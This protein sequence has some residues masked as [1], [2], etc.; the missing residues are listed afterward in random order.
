VIHRYK[1]AQF[2]TFFL[3][4]LAGLAIDLVG[5]HLLVMWG[6]APWQ[7]NAI[8]STV[9]ISA[10]YFLVTRYSFG[11]AQQLSTYALFVGWYV[12]SILMFSTVIQV[13]TSVSGLDA[14]VWKLASVPLS[15]A[16]NYLFSRFI[17][18]P[19]LARSTG[20]TSEP[21]APALG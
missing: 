18:M 8:S 19:R 1:L 14:I 9:A 7:A 20:D 3:G 13:A 6:C 11:V 2:L 4:S 21:S 12:T 17:F 10:V 5:F 15:F 16:L